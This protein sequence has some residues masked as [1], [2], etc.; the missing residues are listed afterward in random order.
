MSRLADTATWHVL[1]G[2]FTRM[3]PTPTQWQL[4]PST[5]VITQEIPQGEVEDLPEFDKAISRGLACVMVP[6]DP[7]IK[8]PKWQKAAEQKLIIDITA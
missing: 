8:A 7:S 6:H 4:L 3:I 5:D 1:E 2:H